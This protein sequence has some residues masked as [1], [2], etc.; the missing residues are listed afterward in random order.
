MLRASEAHTLSDQARTR[1][2]ESRAADLLVR[3]EQA[4][5]EAIARGDFHVALDFETFNS[6][7][8]SRDMRALGYT[9]EPG[10]ARRRRWCVSWGAA[11]E[12]GHG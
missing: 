2:R 1:L 7:E 12:V 8:W 6:A 3:A 5:R 4:V 10:P 9:L 11:K